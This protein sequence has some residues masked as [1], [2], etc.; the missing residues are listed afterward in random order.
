[1]SGLKN[2]ALPGA[3]VSSCTTPGEPF[4]GPGPGDP[5][6]PGEPGIPFPGDP[7][8]PG[9]PMPFPPDPPPD[10]LLGVLEI[11]VESKYGMQYTV[12][13][14][15]TD[16]RRGWWY[17]PFGTFPWFPQFGWV[18]ILEGLTKPT[19]RWEY[20]DPTDEFT[21][22]PDDFNYWHCPT[23]QMDDSLNRTWWAF[24]QGG[25]GG[26]DWDHSEVDAQH[27]IQE[28]KARERLSIPQ[29]VVTPLLF[30]IRGHWIENVPPPGTTDD[31]RIRVRVT[32]TDG[33]VIHYR[34]PMSA[35]PFYTTAN[36]FPVLAVITIPPTGNGAIFAESALGEP[37][38][39][40]VG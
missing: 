23:L 13:M 22:D 38:P 25:A 7:P 18:S 34:L 1:M 9:E 15:D 31:A 33:R 27:I 4:P 2:P 20:D 6:G 24:T 28:S 32:H 36:S 37:I 35:L 11:R 12:E 8:G 26:S 3:T 29:P 5:P 17:A 30:S 40:Y 10:I 39:P 21:Y 14:V 19:D 16:I